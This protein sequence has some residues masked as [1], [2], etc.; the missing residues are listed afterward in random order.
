M[1]NLTE[2][3]ILDSMLGAIRSFARDRK[4][5]ELFDSDKDV[6][7]II[8]DWAYEND[9]PNDPLIELCSKLLVLKKRI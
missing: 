2:E 8:Y 5:V 9:N 7:E 1:E 6:V 3:K 4:E